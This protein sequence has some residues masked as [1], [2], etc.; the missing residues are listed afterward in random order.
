L[1]ADFY[2]RWIEEP[3]PADR[4]A[5][6]AAIRRAT[7]VPIATGEHEYTRWGFLELLKADAIDVLQS[8]PDW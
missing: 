6:F 2:P 7:R 1:R 4:I 5:D 3:V 8:D